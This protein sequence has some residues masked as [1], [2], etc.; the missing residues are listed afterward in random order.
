MTAVHD[1]SKTHQCTVCQKLF[2]IKRYLYIHLKKVHQKI[3]S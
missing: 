3:S 1:K 2:S